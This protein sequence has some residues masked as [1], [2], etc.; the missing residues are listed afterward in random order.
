MKKQFFKYLLLLALL[1]FIK[2]TSHAQQRIDTILH[3]SGYDIHFNI[4]KGKGTPVIFENGANSDLTIWDDVIKPVSSITGAPLITYDQVGLGKSSPD[5]PQLSVPEGVVLLEKALHLLGYDQPAMFVSASWGSMY[6][7]LYAVKHPEKVKIAVISDGVTVCACKNDLR[8]V[9]GKDT[10][11]KSLSFPASIPV[12]DLVSDYTPFKTQTERE[13]WKRC[14]REFVAEAP[15]NRTGILAE[16]CE[17]DIVSANPG[18]FINIVAQA[19]SRIVSP[20]EAALVNKRALAYAITSANELKK[21]EV[22]YRHSDEDMNRWGYSLLGEGKTEQALLVFKL[23]VSLYPSDW[24]VYDS[25]GEALLKAGQKEEAI[26]MYR[27]SI[28]LNPDNEGGKK[29]LKE[30]VN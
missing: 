5:M 11:L 6:I 30:I 14:H 18:L 12:V 4:T 9:S 24:N 15:N 25:Y 8:P 22:R 16:E 7:T 17:H 3:V 19:Y 29:I 10:V 20:S 26:K 23:N 2:T 1:L 28:E 27:R 13:A 21:N